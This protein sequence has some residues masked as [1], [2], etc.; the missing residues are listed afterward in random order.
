MSIDASHSI[1]KLITLA[2]Y[3]LT[4]LGAILVAYSGSED[5]IIEGLEEVGE[6]AALEEIIDTNQDNIETV[7]VNQ[8]RMYA[9]HSKHH[10]DLRSLFFKGIG[11][12]VTLMV[13]LMGL[14]G[15]VI[16]L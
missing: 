14:V 5:N 7:L 15:T 2:S 3:Y 4:T 13:A 1:L 9:L 8:K 6:D 12:L 11:I 16:V 10:Q